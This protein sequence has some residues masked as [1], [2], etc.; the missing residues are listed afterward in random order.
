VTLLSPYHE[1]DIYGTPNPLPTPRIVEGEEE[2]EIEGILAHRQ[3]DNHMEYRVKWK[4]FP[5]EEDEWLKEEDITP[6]T[7]QILDNYRKLQQI[8][9][10]DRTWNITEGCIKIEGKLMKTS[11]RRT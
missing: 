10:Y 7:L 6:H 5:Y 4:N 3:R 8:A 11:E 9:P 1:N 2:Y